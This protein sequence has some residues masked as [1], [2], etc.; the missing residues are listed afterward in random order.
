MGAAGGATGAMIE[1]T[2]L[3]K[4]YGSTVAVAGLDLA[5][6]AGS[7]VALVGANGSGK[8]TTLQMLSTLLPP[9]AGTAR[10][11]GCDLVR[12]PVGV[13][14]A[15]GMVF[16]ETA[17]DRT[18]TVGDNLRFAGALYD[19]PA[20]QVARRSQEL[21]ALFELEGRRATP[22]AA[23]SGGMRRAVDIARGMLHQP[24][25]L[26]LDEPT[27]GLDLGNRR[28][29]WRHLE[30]ARREQRTT[31][32]LATHLL[33]E[34]ADCDLVIFMQGGQ[35][36]GQGRPLELI[37]ALGA[38]VLELAGSPLAT[39]PFAHLGEHRRDGARL[40]IMLRDAAFSLASL[41][42]AAL[43]RLDTVTLR[44]PMLEDVYQRQFGG[45][46]PA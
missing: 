4:R 43:A 26:L 38:W 19:L 27:T 10:I 37:A 23:L 12:D 42:Q 45:T 8:S 22:V 30:R 9:S 15:I 40:S 18:L 28:S 29:V 46:S 31:L 16:Q 1:A 44:R 36:I 33:D 39:A 3:G 6:E 25:V 32:L 21:L 17:L 34:A 5:I 13:R 14:A 2:G 20:D 7:C 41:D 24:S 11:A 35:V